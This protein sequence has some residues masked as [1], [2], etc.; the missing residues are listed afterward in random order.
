MD[1]PFD[2]EGDQ[3]VALSNAFL[4]ALQARESG[5]VD[6][7][8]AALRK[9]VAAE[10]RIAEPHLELARVLLDTDRIEEAEGHAREGLDRLADTGPW[11]EDVE[12]HQ[13]QALA[14]ALL[15][16]IL[17]RRIDDD[18]LVF[19]DPAVYRS[20]L[21]E[22]RHHFEVAARLDPTDEHASW[23]AFFLGKDEQGRPMRLADG[24]TDGPESEN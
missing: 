19:G 14:H 20:T 4:A 12:P 18:D 11:L 13:I 3:L 24:I 15:A 2:D 23:H 10:P 17:R 16:E 5:Q 6:A 9:I 8:E 21:A 1:G 7:A 22:A